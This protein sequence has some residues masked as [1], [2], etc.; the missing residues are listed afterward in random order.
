MSTTNPTNEA[1]ATVAMLTVS[2]A[3]I[4][5]A[6]AGK[7]IVSVGQRNGKNA[8]GTKREVAADQRY[9]GV[10]IPILSLDQSGV[11]NKFQPMLLT[12]LRKTAEKQLDACWEESTNGLREV[13]AA[14]WTVDSLILFA[15]RVSESQRLSTERVNEWFKASK[16]GVYLAKEEKKFNQILALYQRFV[17]GVVSASEKH[18]DDMLALLGRF[19]EEESPIWKGLMNKAQ[20]RLETIK[21]EA[22]EISE[23]IDIDSLVNAPI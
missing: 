16:I 13:P 18:C 9:R 23:D 4:L 3:P 2:S 1:P 11:P 21:K 19:E 12:A 6:D 20:R 14:I 10:Q 7:E 5:N 22:A 17:P 8:D 15:A